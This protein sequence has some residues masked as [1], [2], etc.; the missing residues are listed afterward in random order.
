MTNKKKTLVMTEDILKEASEKSGIPLEEVRDVYY[1]LIR[2][3]EIE[4]ELGEVY[5]M[6]FPML[7]NFV[8]SS[9]LL[10]REMRTV[11]KKSPMYESYKK[12]L[13]DIT[14]FSDTH[15][16]YINKHRQILTEYKLNRELGPEGDRTIRFGKMDVKRDELMIKIENKQNE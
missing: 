13:K 5:S 4:S 10:K 9:E 14:Y 12:R 3:M 7:G 8:L 2:S 15:E 6:H 11:G 1:S 16:D